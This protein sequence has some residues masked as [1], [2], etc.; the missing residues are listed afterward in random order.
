MTTPRKYGHGDGYGS[1]PT[2]NPKIRGKA[3]AGGDDF[4]I[5]KVDRDTRDWR[6]EDSENGLPHIP[7]SA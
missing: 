1:G 3:L 7:D 4:Y 6:E 2:P 5:Q